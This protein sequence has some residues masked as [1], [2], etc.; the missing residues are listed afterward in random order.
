MRP[1]YLEPDPLSHAVRI[2]RAGAA[3]AL[4]AL[5]SRNR[6]GMELPQP[7]A[8]DAK[9]MGCLFWSQFHNAKSRANRRRLFL[10]AKGRKGQLHDLQ[11]LVINPCLLIQAKQNLPILTSGLAVPDSRQS[12]GQGLCWHWL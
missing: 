11:S 1:K 8:L 4:I 3:G 12:G 6:F 7:E 10:G 5:T 2:K 9:L